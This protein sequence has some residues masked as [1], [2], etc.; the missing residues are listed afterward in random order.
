MTPEPLAGHTMSEDKDLPEPVAHMSG[1][2]MRAITETE[3]ALIPN[4]G[5]DKGRRERCR[6]LYRT[7]L[8]TAEQMRAYARASLAQ[9]AGED[10]R[11]AERWRKCQSM[12]KAW[13]LDAID[14][15]SRP[16]HYGGQTLD[17]AIDQAMKGG[18]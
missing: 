11:D 5:G 3:L 16:R 12:A 15:A 7:P 18:C 2:F 14:N 1:D 6:I 8:F 13:W 4:T 10:A 9:Q 17:E